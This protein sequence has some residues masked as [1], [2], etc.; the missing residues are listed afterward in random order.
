MN[1][2]DIEFNIGSMKTI[3]TNRGMLKKWLL[4]FIAFLTF[5]ISLS[6]FVLVY[7]DISTDNIYYNYLKVISYFMPDKT[8]ALGTEK[9]FL[10]QPV[11]IL[12]YDINSE[13]ENYDMRKGSMH[14]SIAHYFSD[15]LSIDNTKLFNAQFEGGTHDDIYNV[16]IT[17]DMFDEEIIIY[18]NICEFDIDDGFTLIWNVSLPKRNIEVLILSNNADL[19]DILY[20]VNDLLGNNQDLSYSIKKVQW[21]ADSK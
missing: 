18:S 7:I 10:K 5:V 12:K 15:T 20:L 8:I 21:G 9:I 3:Q 11:Q 4:V 1:N 16:L 19:K 14:L 17:I 2:N 13:S 6:L